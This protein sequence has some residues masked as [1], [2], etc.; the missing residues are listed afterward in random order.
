MSRLHHAIYLTIIA[1]LLVSIFGLLIPGPIHDTAPAA[2]QNVAVYP[3]VAIDPES[4]SVAA[5]LTKALVRSLQKI[6]NIHVLT[7][8]DI[9]IGMRNPSTHDQWLETG[10]VSF[11]LEGSVRSGEDGEI[12]V[13]QLVDVSSDAHSWSETFEADQVDIKRVVA[14]V[15]SQIGLITGQEEE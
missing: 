5:E 2:S 12:V 4:E 7:G 11:L 13:A 8:S 6:P 1:A 10:P 3:F 14:S 15:E 9:P